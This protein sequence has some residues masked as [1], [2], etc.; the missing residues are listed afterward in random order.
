MK[1][2]GETY[3]PCCSATFRNRAVLIRSIPTSGQPV[4]LLVD[5]FAPRHALLRRIW[6]PCAM[7]GRGRAQPKAARP[8][9]ACGQ[10]CGYDTNGHVGERCRFQRVA[11]LSARR[12]CPKR[13]AQGIALSQR[14]PLVP[15]P[16]MPW[17]WG[18][19]GVQVMREAEWETLY[20]S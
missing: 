14:T 1:T 16:G 20:R 3:S 12:I 4:H 7:R 13:C 15:G 10:A 2:V 5:C 9:Q 17:T 6:R 18:E 8:G 19:W 11:S